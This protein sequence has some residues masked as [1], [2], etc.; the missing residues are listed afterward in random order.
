MKKLFAI[1]LALTLLFAISAVSL[2]EPEDGKAS[3]SPEPSET[4]ED[5]YTAAKYRLDG[6]DLLIPEGLGDGE[7]PSWDFATTDDTPEKPTR[8]FEIIEKD[9]TYAMQ[10][11]DSEGNPMPVTL[12]PD[13]SVVATTEDFDA[14][15]VVIMTGGAE[16]AVPCK[17]NPEGTDV[18]FEP[19]R[20][21]PDKKIKPVWIPIETLRTAADE[22][23]SPG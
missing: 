2:A 21:D 5:K 22:P 6:A 15:L 23:D 12:Q 10:Y 20:A 13:S 4:P 11:T 16:T 3:P 19:V 17:A 18:L 14:V 8:K 7:L 9:G 1:L